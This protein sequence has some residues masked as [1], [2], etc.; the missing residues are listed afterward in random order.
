MVFCGMLHSLNINKIEE[1]NT[2]DTTTNLV[3]Y[4]YTSTNMVTNFAGSGNA[5][6]IDDTGTS[7]T[8]NRPI[9]VAITPDGLT[10]LVADYDN[11]KI[12]AI[13][14]SNKVVTTIASNIDSPMGL[15][16]HPY[17][18]YALVLS[19]NTHMVLK[20]NIS[21]GVVTTF[22]G[23]GNN[24]S[25]DGT[26]TNASF[27]HPQGI[28]IDPTGTFALVADTSAHKIRKIILSTGVVSTVA[29][30]SNTYGQHGNNDG[31]GTSAKF[32]LPTDVAIDPTGT[33]AL[34]ADMLNSRIRH[35]NLSSF[36]VSTLAGSNKGFLDGNGT[37]AKFNRPYS[38]AISPDGTTALAA[39][40]DNDNIRAINISTGDVTTIAG[41]T[42]FEGSPGSTNGVG[43]GTSARFNDPRG[44][45][46]S[47][48]GST[49]LV[50][51]SENDKIRAI[52]FNEIAE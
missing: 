25:I 50:T 28:V 45:T 48:D 31:T 27:R 6:S 10:A 16:I 37:S 12:R 9:R 4:H 24:E 40:K 19:Y 3:Y 30:Y 26:G 51:D 22:A 44:V 38:I 39:D 17:H 1:T 13:D 21:T 33:F 35:I 46:I 34:V 29:G 52:I 15:A 7:A 36:Y 18:D 41:S 49:A 23:T 43:I 2:T 42:S 32:W 11:G 47:P 20:I 8:F 14:I 5:G